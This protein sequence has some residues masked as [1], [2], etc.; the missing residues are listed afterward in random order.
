VLAV[1][2]S[3]ILARNLLLESPLMAGDEYGYFAPVQTFPNLSE[4][5]AVDPYLPRYYSPLFSAYGAALAIVSSRPELLL[6]ALN[7]AGFIAVVLLFLALIRRLDPTR[8]TAPT[9]MV[10][11]LL[12]NSAYTAYVMPEMMYTLLFAALTWFVVIAL[13][14]RIQTAAVLS[15]VVV[16]AMLLVKPH[17]VALV[18]A[19]PLTLGAL[20][21]A[22]PSIRPSRRRVLTSIPLFIVSTYATLVCMNGLIAGRLELSPFAF[23]GTVY[24]GYFSG[25]FSAASWLG[26]SRELLSIVGGHA[27]VL[28]ALVAPAAALAAAEL[29]RLYTTRETVDSAMRTRFLLIVFTV[30]ATL[31]TVA[32]TVNFTAQAAQREPAYHFRLHGRYYSFVLPLYL[33][34]FFGLEGHQRG[35]WWRRTGALVGVVAAVLLAYLESHR[36]LYPFDYPEAFVF[37]SWHGGLRSG[38][39][40]IGANALTQAGIAFAI[41]GYAAMLWRSKS[42]ARWYP[43][44]LIALF[45]VS[46]VRVSGWQWTNSTDNSGIRADARSMRQIIAPSERNQG[47]VVGPE[48]NGPIAYF[49]FNFNASARVLVR[50]TG[51]RITEADLPPGTPWVLLIGRYTPTF[52]SGASLYTRRV[53]LIRVKGANPA[54]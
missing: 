16:G 20:V 28:A 17:A 54:F 42:V 48:W 25:G 53:T 19:V 45:A 47:L 23:V 44:L 35:V 11:A 13:A 46:N 52:P 40:A 8:A 6:K 51:S 12:P 21:I 15:G 26:H 1:V 2:G 9:A 30:A 31:I 49:L 36:T 39:A 14:T 34:I 43:M 18:F 32:M 5:F 29:H 37:S 10:F 27:I 24:Q 7:T 38:L 22:P 50:D 41:V 3:L 4:R 33:A